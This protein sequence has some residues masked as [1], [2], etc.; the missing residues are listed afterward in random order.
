MSDNKNSIY[1]KSMLFTVVVA[2]AV[3]IGSVITAFVPL[4]MK[5][6]HPKLDNLKPYT[7][8]QLAGR[9]LYVKEGCFNCHTQTVRPLKADV[10]RYGEY[11][12]AGENYYEHPFLWGSKRTGPDLAR[13]GGKYPDQWHI[14]HFNNP[15]AFYPLSNMPKYDWLASKPIDIVQTRRGM[16]VLDFPY[17]QN[18]I[19]DLKSKTQLDAMVAYMQVVGSSVARKS[20]VAVSPEDYQDA[21]NPFK[22]DAASAEKGRLLYEVHCF[23]C[24]GASGEG[25]NIASGITDLVDEN[26]SDGQIFLAI[27]NGLP[28]MMEEHVNVMTKNDI[29]DLVSY[30]RMLAAKRQASN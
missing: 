28:G 23:F 12:K 7:A 2:V 4:A 9:D 26:V 21:Q 30:C 3:I 5:D 22:D 25:T 6:M 27:A 10:L 8:L 13:I 1:S 19:E 14:D 24:H 20:Y 18:D 11:S 17:T 29:W 15:Q 16:D